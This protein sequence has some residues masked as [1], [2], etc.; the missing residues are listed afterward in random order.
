MRAI[1]LHRPWANLMAIG[2]KR[3]E[4][5]GFY[6]S[7]RGD[8]AIHAAQKYVH[9]PELLEFIPRENELPT[10]IVCIVEL[11]NCVQITG[12]ETIPHPEILF[13][14]YEPGRFMWKTRR[15]RVFT[16][17][18]WKGAQGFFQ[19]PDNILEATYGKDNVHQ[20]RDPEDPQGV[21]F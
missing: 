4:T 9:V 20:M 17:I 12:G 8:L 21:L 15:L 5:R 11:Y 13:G 18:P 19:V 2:L 7:Y 10:G 14:N 6:T 16:P 1:S 3:I